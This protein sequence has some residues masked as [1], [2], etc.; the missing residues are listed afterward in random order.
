MTVYDLGANI[1][2]ISLILGHLVGET[3]RVFAFEALPSN[4]ERWRTNV[5]LNGLSPRMQLFCGA[6]TDSLAPVHFLV[7]A[8]GG[9][10]KAVGSAGREN[11]YKNELEVPGISLDEFVFTQDFPPPQ[12]IKM[13]IEG[14]E[15]LA[16]PGMK[17]LLS[18]THPS[19]LMELHG[20]ASSE[21]VWK[22]LTELGYRMC[23]MKPGFPVVKALEELDWKAYLVALPE[24]K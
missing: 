5:D 21:V 19:L 17:R 13:D 9:M 12:V 14:G 11:Y 16:L 10:G 15:V 23:W 7:H 2:Y 18:E 20:K 8:S 4:T 24:S 6:V 3:G 1:G 22:T